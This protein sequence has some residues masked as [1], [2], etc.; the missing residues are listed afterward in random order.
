[1]KKILIIGDLHGKDVWKTFAD[2]K[3]LLTA[4]PE[5]AGYGPFEP[6]YDHYV[7]LG[8]YVDAFD[9]DNK[10]IMENLLDIMRFKTLYPYH[11]ILLWGN[12]DVAYY[13]NMPCTGMRPEMF[14]DLRELF[15]KNENLF[16]VA[17]QIEN[18]IFLHGGLHKGWYHFVFTKAIK[19]MGLD[20]M[21]VA[22]QLNEAFRQDVPC[23]YDI[24]FYRGGRK[25][26][27][28]PLWIS[29]QLLNKKPLMNIHQYVGHTPVDHITTIK[30]NKETTVTYCD[31]LRKN[32]NDYL[33]VKI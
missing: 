31:T 13:R 9:K 7:F 24:D 20:E 11:V 8:D 2:I 3:F 10:T 25:K 5:A 21:G 12:H 32:T 14:D 1:M 18:H 27:G 6:E 29:K 19:D 30:I 28:G 17:F 15:E 33:V 26:V 4:E 23:I 16:Q 22:D